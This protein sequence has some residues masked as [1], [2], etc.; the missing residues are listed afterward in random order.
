MVLQVESASVAVLALG[1]AVAVA[2]CWYGIGELRLANRILRSRPDSV[3]D[4]TDGGRIE[5]RG[6]ARPVDDGR[7]CRAPLSDTPCLAYEYE[8]ERYSSSKNGSNWSTIDADEG[9][10][11]FLLED[12]SGN[13][14]IEPP[15]ADLRLETDNR[16]TVDAGT[17]PP[18]TIAR[19]IEDTD[20]IDDQATGSDRGILDRLTDSDRRFTE[21]L[22]VPDEEVHVLGTARYDT[23]VSSAPG[24]VNAAVG[25]DEA[26]YADSRW[27]R[28]RHALFGD[29]FIISDSTERR[30]GLRA[31]AQGLLTLGIGALAAVI[32]VS[33]AL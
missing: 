31:G 29:P 7:R 12:D 30:L 20:A 25:V 9:Y 28:L 23:T 15:G 26:A 19:F 24:Q 21:R 5:L 18:S 2:F 11:P 16:I 1:A 4:T 27:L 13:V 32:A 10:V 17:E 6:T 3:L 8:I 22:L 14:L 33:W